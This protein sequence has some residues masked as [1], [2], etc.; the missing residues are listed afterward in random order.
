MSPLGSKESSFKFKKKKVK[1]NQ[2]KKKQPNLISLP[3]STIPKMPQILILP[4]DGMEGHWV[5][6]LLRW[7][8]N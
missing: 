4:R 7:V 1:K 5:S 2:K 3:I 6:D 8:A